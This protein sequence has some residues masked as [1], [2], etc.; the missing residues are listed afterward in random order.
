M[1]R[2][3]IKEVQQKQGYISRPFMYQYYSKS[4][5]NIFP[6]QIIKLV[7]IIISPWENRN[8][9]KTLELKRGKTRIIPTYDSWA[10]YLSTLPMLP[11]LQITKCLNTADESSPARSLL[12]INTMYLLISMGL[13][14]KAAILPVM[15]YSPIFMWM[16]C[17]T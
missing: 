13:L 3:N 17:L 8:L 14:P 15:S 16:R 2:K 7:V 11:P 4:F 6:Q 5:T 1:I 10:F 12:P 9:S